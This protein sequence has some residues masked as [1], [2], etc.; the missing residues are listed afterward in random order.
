M[1]VHPC[2]ARLLFSGARALL[3]SFQQT[4][5]NAGM[6]RC[7]Q[8]VQNILFR[9]ATLQYDNPLWFWFKPMMALSAITD[10]PEHAVIKTIFVH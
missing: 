9:N 5:K 10:F 2:V 6:N 8:G 7:N 1:G 4:W 3:Q